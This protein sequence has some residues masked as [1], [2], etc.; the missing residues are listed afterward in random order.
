MYILTIDYITK[1]KISTIDWS[2]LHSIYVFMAKKAKVITKYY[3][4]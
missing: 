2:K 1:L 4:I 3:S